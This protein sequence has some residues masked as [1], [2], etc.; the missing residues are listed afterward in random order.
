[1]VLFIILG[2]EHVDQST[3]LYKDTFFPSILSWHW[4]LTMDLSCLSAY[5]QLQASKVQLEKNVQTWQNLYIWISFQPEKHSETPCQS[6]WKLI[7]DVCNN[8]KITYSCLYIWIL[9]WMPKH[10]LL[11]LKGYKFFSHKSCIYLKFSHWFEN[12]SK[13]FYNW[14]TYY[15]SLDIHK[16]AWQKCF[17]PAR[18]QSTKHL[19][20]FF[21]SC[22]TIGHY[23]S[24]G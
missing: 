16:H 23:W 7:Y 1:M 12:I 24:S 6:P 8:L 21:L 2:S 10:V 9:K 18:N 22:A 13:L 11:P 4:D 14:R 20:I 17:S 15:I 19:L 3:F 5:C